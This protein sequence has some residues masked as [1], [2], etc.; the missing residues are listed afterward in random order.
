[1]GGLAILAWWGIIPRDKFV[2][3][4]L[5][6]VVALLLASPLAF[7]SH[8]MARMRTYLPTGEEWFKV[9]ADWQVGHSCSCYQLIVVFAPI[10]ISPALISYLSHLS[11]VYSH[12]PPIYPYPSGG[13]GCWLVW[14][15]CTTSDRAPRP[16][17]GWSVCPS[18]YGPSGNGVL[19]VVSC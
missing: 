15:A 8:N 5:K 17:Y 2:G 12:I 4:G 9:A 13:C 10:I 3:L 1:V 6:T 7:I 19:I 16:S 18:T 11:F 14:G